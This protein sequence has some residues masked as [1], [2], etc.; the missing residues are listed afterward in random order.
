MRLLVFLVFMVFFSLPAYPQHSQTDSLTYALEE[1]S[2]SVDRINILNERAFWYIHQDPGLAIVDVREALRLSNMLSYDEGIARAHNVM[3]GIHWSQ[4]EYDQAL[5]SYFLALKKYDLLE[6]RLGSVKCYNNLGLIYHRLG[7]YKKALEYL[8]KAR[9]GAEG[10]SRPLMIYINLGELF[11]SLGDVDS[12]EFYIQKA[13]D[14][15]GISEQPRPLGL[16]YR[17]MA[18]IYLKKGEYGLALENAWLG[19]KESRRSAEKRSIATAY[20]QL[21]HIYYL[22]SEPDSSSHYYE[23]ALELASDISARDI[24]IHIYQSISGIYS[25]HQDFESALEYFRHYAALRDTMFNERRAGLIARLQT[26]YE[27]DLLIRERENAEATIR[28]RNVVIIAT[29]LLLF[30]SLALAYGLYRQKVAARKFNTLLKTK[31]NQISRQN[32]MIRSQSKELK[33]LNLNLQE[34][35]NNLEEKVR[36]STQ[37]LQRKNKTLADYAYASAHELRGPV[38]CVLGLSN[39]LQSSTLADEEREVVEHLKKA[40]D[41]LDEV[42]RSLRER[43]EADE[44]LDRQ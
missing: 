18:D 36:S 17:G 31:T 1:T 27:T 15:P 25:D 23:A 38:A 5:D 43:L 16:A 41:E 34:L 42:M 7:D 44:Q 2:Q 20:E 39:I 4:G 22:L 13:F 11:I 12:A 28:S 19:L 8:K 9:L 40:T 26:E 3:G 32:L 6:D 35:N 29:V 33:S 10:I 24:Q 30:I 37:M 14:H 21:G